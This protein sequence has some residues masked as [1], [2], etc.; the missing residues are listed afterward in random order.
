MTLLP[1]PEGVTV[2]ADH[3]RTF[4]KNGV[5]VRELTSDPVI[6][7]QYTLYRF[8]LN[9][10]ALS[11]GHTSGRLGRSSRLQRRRTR[12]HFLKARKSLPISETIYERLTGQ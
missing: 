4:Y 9:T 2:T 1:I 7:K 12:I 11:E 3:C 5:R 6:S 10:L 8:P